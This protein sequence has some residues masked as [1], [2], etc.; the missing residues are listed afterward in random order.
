M[1]VFFSPTLWRILFLF[2]FKEAAQQKIMLKGQQIIAEFLAAQ[3]QVLDRPLQIVGCLLIVQHQAHWR[4][5]VIES[6]ASG[7]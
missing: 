1:W 6:L 7:A 3:P 4:G 5:D 2:L